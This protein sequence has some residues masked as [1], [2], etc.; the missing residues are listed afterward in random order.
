MSKEFEKIK[1]FFELSEEERTKHFEGVFDN[2]ADFFERFNHI[3]KNGTPEE[4]KQVLEELQEVQQFVE[5]ETAKLSEKTGL[6]PEQLK[7]YADDKSHFSEEQWNAIQ[8]AR[9]RIVHDSEDV[10]SYLKFKPEVPG[11]EAPKNKSPKP[12]KKGWEKA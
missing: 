5:K 8:G 7:D 11:S 1:E 10:K 4:K 2:A 12:K 9:E 6:T 3:I